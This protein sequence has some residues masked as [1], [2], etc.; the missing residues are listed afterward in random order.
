MLCACAVVISLIGV[1]KE[2]LF[3]IFESLSYNCVCVVVYSPLS[4]RYL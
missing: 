2:A 4:Y 3:I 1:N